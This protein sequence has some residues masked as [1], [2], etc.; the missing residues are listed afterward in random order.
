MTKKIAIAKIISAFGIK[1]EVKVMIYSNEPE[2]IEKYQLFFADGAPLKLKISNKNKTII[3]TSSDNPIILAKIDGV[4]DRN[5]S[6]KLRGQ[7]IF[8]ARDSFEQTSDDEFYY[9][10]L[11]G[12]E[13]IDMNSKKIGKVSNVLDHGA[14]G[15]IEIEFDQNY[16]QNS[17]EKIDNFS[18]KNSIFPEVNLR[19]GFIRID[20]PEFVEID[21]PH[22]S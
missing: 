1:G 22:K 18:F 17:P 14:G 15:I 8:A 13:V 7:E 20:L 19:Q 5:A 21:K 3:G 11:I 6:E 2:K 16:Q 10:D 12:L 4:N 9:V